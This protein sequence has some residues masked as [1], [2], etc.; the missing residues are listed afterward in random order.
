MEAARN[1]FMYMLPL[2]GGLLNVHTRGKKDD[3]SCAWRVGPT[4][5][6]I[7]SFDRN[8]TAPITFFAYTACV[9]SASSLCHKDGV[10]H[11]STTIIS[12]GTSQRPTTASVLSASF[13]SS[14]PRTSRPIVKCTTC[15]TRRELLVRYFLCVRER[16]WGGELKGKP[17]ARMLTHFLCINKE[18]DNRKTPVVMYLGIRERE[19]T[20]KC[21]FWKWEKLLNVGM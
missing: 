3:C 21:Y 13:L 14:V 15:Q 19:F 20:L 12:W 18:L 7:L 1:V 10:R 8:M 11:K 2:G 17:L 4:L 5:M 16:V 9:F 6:G